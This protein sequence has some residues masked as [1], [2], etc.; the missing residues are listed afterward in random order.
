MGPGGAPPLPGTEIERIRSSVA[1]YFPVYETRI[2][3]VS[4]VLLVQ[5]DPATLE[6]RFDRLRQE[7]WT[8]YYIPQIRKDGGEYLIEVIRR[9]RRAPWSSLTNVVLL[10]VTILTTMLAGAFLWVAYVG[11]KT[12]MPMDVAYGAAYFGLPLLG[13]LGVHELAHFVMARRHHVEAS[14]PYFIPVPPPFL[15][16][17]TFGAFISL[18]EPIPSKKAL[19]DI[20][21]SGPLAGF[22]VAIPVTIAGMFL[23][24]HAPVL[25]VANCG[26][27]FFGVGYGNLIV[28][29]SVL[30]YVLTL[31]VPVS[32]V[33]LH[34]LALA[35]W[36]GLLV[37][38]INLLP[39]G[40]LD[41]GHVFRALFGDRTRWVSYGAVGLLLI[42][43]LAYPGWFLFAILIVVLGM[44]HPPP[45]NDISPLDRKRVA[46]GAMAVAVLVTGFVLIPI[47]S[48]SGSFG[49]AA[50]P[51]LSQPS[52]N[53]FG[54]HD[55]TTVSVDNKDLVAHGYVLAGSIV[56]VTG[57]V[58]GTTQTLT[59]PEL[60]S[61]L[62]NSTWQVTL[63]NGNVT[64]F[65]GTG[66]F[67]VP[68]AEYSQV[69]AG[70]RGT[71]T[72]VYTNVQQAS[73]TATLTVE[74]LCSGPASPN[75][76]VTVTMS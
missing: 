21:A 69:N 36:V 51:V 64:A 26:P 41:G 10:G 22:A 53:A 63:P 23:S 50:G 55:N 61:F 29:T 38:A 54:M 33:S 52:V 20:G 32:F 3:P 74:E 17:G 70:D 56:S 49:V 48:P 72:V 9:P 25:S 40:Q 76:G 75:E 31:F 39:A 47:A 65:G 35:G 42:L 7:F 67:S 66:S 37:T 28:G 8:K 13:I 68:S 1:L 18:R 57:S 58:N 43:G 16:F 24:A 14:L 27:S 59:G 2:T 71:F 30:W 46:I 6:E 19:L 4:L 12:L 15:L 11:G 34:P 73:V 44:R 5:A 60:A 62:A 45:L